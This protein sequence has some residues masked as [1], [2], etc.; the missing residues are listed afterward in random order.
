MEGALRAVEVTGTVDEQRRLHLDEPLPVNGPGRVRV[1]VLIPEEANVEEREWLRAAAG[2][3]AFG[4]LEDEEEDI[5]TL[6]DGRPFI[7]QG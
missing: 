6:T 2:N 1:I 3:P 7:D 5:Y 4:F